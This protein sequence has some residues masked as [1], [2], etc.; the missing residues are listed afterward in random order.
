MRINSSRGKI[1]VIGISNQV[2]II[3]TY[4]DPEDGKMFPN[5]AVMLKFSELY[6]LIDPQRPLWTLHHSGL[7][8]RW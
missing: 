5:D 4:L 8:D 2:H 1:E 3:Q 6:P 7:Q